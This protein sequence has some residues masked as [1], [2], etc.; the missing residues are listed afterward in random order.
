MP[1]LSGEKRRQFRSYLELRLR[2]LYGD[3]FQDFVGDVLVRIHGSN[4]VRQCPWGNKG[5]LS[6]DGYLKDPATIFACYGAR[7]GS[8]R[9]FD[10]VE[11]K[12]VADF[13]GAREKW[14]QMR[15]WVFVSN[16]SD[17]T[18]APVVAALE[19]LASGGPIK[20]E[21][22]GF[23]RFEAELLRL[24]EE[25][26]ADLI[27]PM[28][29][30]QD[31]LKLQPEAVQQAVGAIAAEFS[32]KYLAEATVPVPVDK[33]EI[34]E[35]PAV[36]AEQIK[37]GLLGRRVVEACVLDNADASLEGRLSDAFRQKYVELALQGFTPGAIVDGLYD[38]ATAGLTETTE[39]MTAAWAVIAYFFEK[40]TIFRD[41][42]LDSAGQAHQG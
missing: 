18:P 16:L 20:V 15:G 5:D 26:V 36:H 2:R 37:R 42:P 14:P 30:H 28:P 1:Q 38:F 3:A 24:D 4:F 19:Q 6:C 40:C 25:D 11:A 12:V 41:R 23:D 10:A 27:G 32:L 7:S 9:R 22:F 29:M 21:Y 39:Q 13:Q 31:F 34:N 17:A 33:L 8:V 35:I